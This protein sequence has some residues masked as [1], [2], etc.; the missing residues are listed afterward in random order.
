[1]AKASQLL[2]LA[3]QEKESYSELDWSIAKALV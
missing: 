3:F 1:M 2:F